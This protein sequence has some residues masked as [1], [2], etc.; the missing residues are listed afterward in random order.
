MIFLALTCLYDLFCRNVTHVWIEI[1]F[2]S[3][4][5][6]IF[7]SYTS[8]WPTLFIYRLLPFFENF[9]RHRILS[10]S[11]CQTVIHGIENLHDIVSIM[12]RCFRI[13]S[14]IWRIETFV[15]SIENPIYRECNICSMQS[16]GTSN[17]EVTSLSMSS[18]NR[19]SRST[20]TSVFNF[21]LSTG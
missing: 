13:A 1:W 12:T 18:Q 14:E 4:F 17:I 21:F 15:C 7:R 20:I 10:I 6:F 19:I 5:Q 11:F 9:F 3:I 8:L 16:H 2:S